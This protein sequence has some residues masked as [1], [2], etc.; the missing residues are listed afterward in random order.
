MKMKKLTAILLV[1][2]CLL[3]MTGCRKRSLNYIIQ[4]ED[5]ITG[6]VREVHESYILIYIENSGYPYGADCTVSLDVEYEDS[7]TQFQVGDVVTVYYEGGIMETY[8]LQVGHVYAILL[9]TP[10]DRSINEVS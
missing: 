10:A 8:P 4:H 7:M 9:D 5:H 3:T 2:A 6:V 1:F